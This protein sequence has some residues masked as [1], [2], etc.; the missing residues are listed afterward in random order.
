MNVVGP[1]SVK[2]S[3]MGLPYI[4]VTC[5]LSPFCVKKVCNT[6]PY[7]TLKD[8]ASSLPCFITISNSII[9]TRLLFNY[10]WNKSDY[11]HLI[12]KF[13]CQLSVV[14]CQPC[15]ARPVL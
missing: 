7:L 9:K 15:P 14:I 11:D 10:L 2:P 1:L 13:P 6:V 5:P 12:N 8:N 3:G 4:L